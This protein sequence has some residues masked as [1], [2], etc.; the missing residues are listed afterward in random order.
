VM[1]PTS[2]A[3]SLHASADIAQVGEQ[4]HVTVPA[5]VL[6]DL[7]HSVITA[8]REALQARDAEIERLA[9]RNE[10]LERRLKLAA[11]MW[12]PFGAVIQ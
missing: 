2:R 3:Q 8:Q 11:A 6:V 9:A 10:H 5:A 7:A 1:V 12:K 4:E